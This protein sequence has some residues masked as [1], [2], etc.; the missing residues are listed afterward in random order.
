MENDKITKMYIF[1]R[2]FKILM[3]A[4]R[5]R[6]ANQAE[7]ENASH[8]PGAAIGYAYNLI[9]KLHKLTPDL[10]KKISALLEQIDVD[11]MIFKT[12]PSLD[13]QCAFMSG[14]QVGDRGLLEKSSI[15]EFRKMA[16]LTQTQLAD[17]MGVSQKDI[18]R[19]ENGIVRPSTQSLKQLAD[20]LGCKVDDIID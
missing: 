8:N 15:A 16:K 2:L 19:W 10:D 6:G 20:A 7:L 14:F 5:P 4:A 1:G 18:S 17:K 11:D 13:M 12:S 9:M 3:D